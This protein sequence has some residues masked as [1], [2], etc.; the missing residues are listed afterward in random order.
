MESKKIKALLAAAE[1]G[2]LTADAARNA[3][4]VDDRVRR[5]RSQNGGNVSA[6]L[7]LISRS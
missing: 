3:S 1:T 2:S 7:I 4:S 6:F 5:T